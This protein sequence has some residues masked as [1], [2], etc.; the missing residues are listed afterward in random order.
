[1]VI[2]LMDVVSKFPITGFIMHF[3]G[4]FVGLLMGIAYVTSVV[5]VD[6]V[7][8]LNVPE[9]LEKGAGLSDPMRYILSAIFSAACCVIFQASPRQIPLI[10]FSV[11]VC[12][13]MMGAFP[14]PDPATH[15]IIAF[16]LGLIVRSCAG[17][18]SQLPEASIYV[19]MLPLVPG[20]KIVRSSFAALPHIHKLDYIFAKVDTFFPPQVESIF[21]CIV[22]AV[23]LVGADIFFNR[24]IIKYIVRPFLGPYVLFPVKRYLI[25]TGVVSRI[26]SFFDSFESVLLFREKPDYAVT[27][28]HAPLQSPPT[29]FT[30]KGSQALPSGA[31]IF[32]NDT[33]QP[34]GST[35][36]ATT[37]LPYT[38]QSIV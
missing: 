15:G 36:T 9:L 10:I 19:A 28:A 32:V 14:L 6:Q 37:P 27:N 24:V 18:L 11:L 35:Y 26:E 1:M 38:S 30:T 3:S 12:F 21:V 20:S 13:A 5:V 25:S 8:K 7:F 31:V 17:M 2:G 4:L 16:F 22:V 29:V 33:N 34:L 23:G